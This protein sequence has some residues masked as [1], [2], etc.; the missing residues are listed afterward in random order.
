MSLT[1]STIKVEDFYKT[2]LVDAIPASWDTEFEVWVV[3]ANTKWWIIVNPESLSLRE[4]MFYHWISWSKIQ[5]RWINRISPKVHDIWAWVQ[6]NDTSLIFNYLSEIADTTFYVEKISATQVS[7]WGWP[8]IVW[9]L[10]VSVADTTLTLT[11]WVTN[12]IYYKKSNNTIKI[13][14]ST[15]SVTA[16]WWIVKAEIFSDWTTISSIVYR[17]H[18]MIEWTVWPTWLTWPKWDNWDIW[19]P[20]INWQTITDLNTL[21]TWYT[22]STDNAT[23]VKITETATW[24]STLYN[25]TWIYTLDASNVTTSSNLSTWT[26]W[27]IWTIEWVIYSNLTIDTLWTIRYTGKPAYRDQSNTFQEINTFEDNTIFKWNAIF[28]YYI[29]IA[30]TELFDCDLGTKQKFSWSDWAAHTLD[31]SNVY[32]WNSLVFA[33]NVTSAS[34]TLNKW[35]ATWINSDWTSKAYSFYSIG[36]TTYPLTLAVGTHFFVWEVFSDAIH[37]MYSWASVVI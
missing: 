32:P 21:Q 6:I 10:E 13:S 37:L 26:W 34:C 3:P 8:V 20:W 5:V 36:W 4:R 28:P 12:Y 33:I 30:N 11:T 24:N 25:L 19:T 22:V 29:N 1:T 31:F 18:S 2:V 7:V 15:L 23:Y 9:D 16:D 14:T 35:I 27:T 17:K